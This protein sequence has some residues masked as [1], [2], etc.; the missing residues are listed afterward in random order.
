[1]T[2]ISVKEILY[3][4][5]MCVSLL[6]LPFRSTREYGTTVVLFTT[7]NFFFNYTLAVTALRLWQQVFISMDYSV[8]FYT[9]IL[10]II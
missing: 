8:D 2:F 7:I 3:F 4:T 6:L 5:G 1:M 9:Y 10:V